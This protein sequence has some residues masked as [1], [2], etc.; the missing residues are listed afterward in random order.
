MSGDDRSFLAHLTRRVVLFDG[1]MGTM[2]IAA[3]MAK[4]EVPEAWVLQRAD[5]IAKVHDAYLA[6]GAQVVT[7]ATFGANRIKLK[8][9]GV[10]AELDAPTVNA[11][12]VEIARTAIDRSGQGDCWIAGDIGPTGQFF[13]PM[14]RLD[15]AEARAAFAEQALALER[16]GV[17]L[18]LVETM[19][20]LREAVEAVRGV[21]RVSTRPIVVTL[22]F[23]QRPRG[24]FTLVGDT[25][26]KAADV[27]TGEG[28]DVLGANCSLASAGMLELARVFRAATERPLLFQPNA[29][30]P[31]ME[32]GNPTYR[33][34]PRQFA[35]DVARL[36]ET[37]AN[38]VGGCCGTTPEFI[39]EAARLLAR[40]ATPQ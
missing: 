32:S 3:G 10:I 14:G 20:D 34:T 39:R 28:A 24:F 33:Q 19:Y 27:L 17:D 6:A 29:G 12:A 38:A 22:T 15:A 30:Q 8:S 18:F 23:E 7:T 1:G 25:P 35:E 40:E 13:P 2:L 5:E 31:V 9:G 4:G 36:V 26:A 11:R 21:R 37:G 16:A